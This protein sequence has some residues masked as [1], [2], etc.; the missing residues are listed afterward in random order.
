MTVVEMLKIWQG[1]SMPWWEKYRVPTQTLYQ[2]CLSMASSE[3]AH[4]FSSLETVGSYLSVGPPT[5]NAHN[6]ELWYWQSSFA[7]TS[8]IQNGAT[9]GP[10][11]A[12]TMT[13]VP[14]EKECPRAISVAFARFSRLRKCRHDRPTV[15]Q[16]WD[17]LLPPHLH[18]DETK[19]YWLGKYRN[20][21]CTVISSS[22]QTVICPLRSPND[23]SPSHNHNV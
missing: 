7:L 20:G 11:G 21:A 15:I 18:S 19:P 5:H 6:T 13:N 14:T 1:S 17:L 10:D 2:Q 22:P 3:P 23:L 16:C 12:A 9:T 4:P 8:A